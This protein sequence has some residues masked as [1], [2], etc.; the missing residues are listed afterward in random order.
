MWV[1]AIADF[2]ADVAGEVAKAW[3]GRPGPPQ[4]P[5]SRTVGAVGAGGGDPNG[6]PVCDGCGAVGRGGHGGN[7]PNGR[8]R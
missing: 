1:E 2:V 4:R 6:G 8:T 5:A 7:C 3:R